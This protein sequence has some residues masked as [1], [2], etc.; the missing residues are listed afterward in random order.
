MTGVIDDL[1]KL[2]RDVFGLE[3]L[4]VISDNVK[5]YKQAQGRRLIFD[6]TNR[7]VHSIAINTD[8]K[9]FGTQNLFQMESF[10]YDQVQF[11]SNYGGPKEVELMLDKLQ[12]LGVLDNKAR[13]EM[14]KYF[15][16]SFAF[17][18]G[19][20]TNPYKDVVSD[21]PKN[22]PIDPRINEERIPTN[23]KGDILKPDDTLSLN[24]IRH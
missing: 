12:E 15:K 9:N 5:V 22:N 16:D 18:N 13:E 14:V 11:M 8:G 17:I 6:D 21:D 7:M 4:I 20:G 2:Y 23:S 1:I 3:E 10:M 19:Y 24:K